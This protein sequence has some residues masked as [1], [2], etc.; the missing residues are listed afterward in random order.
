M[1]NKDLI[2]RSANNILMTSVLEI[3]FNNID[4]EAFD[5]SLINNIIIFISE[6]IIF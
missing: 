3:S 1:N 5:F 6:S 4:W 2:V